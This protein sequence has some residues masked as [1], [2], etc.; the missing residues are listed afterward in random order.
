MVLPVTANK[1]LLLCKE[2]IVFLNQEMLCMNNLGLLHL[3]NSQKTFPR[4]EQFSVKDSTSLLPV[5]EP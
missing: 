5:M 3:T 2:K 4:E 1:T